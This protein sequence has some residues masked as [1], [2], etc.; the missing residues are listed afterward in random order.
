MVRS[1]IYTLSEAMTNSIV[2]I[3]QGAPTPNVFRIGGAPTPPYP[4]RSVTEFGLPAGYALWRVML[5]M[6][7]VTCEGEAAD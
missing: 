2:S 3:G 6:E 4:L 7:L 5:V 1:A